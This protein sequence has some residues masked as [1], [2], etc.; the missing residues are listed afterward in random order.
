MVFSSGV[1]YGKFLK[2][3]FQVATPST[4]MCE[5]VRIFTQKKDQVSKDWLHKVCFNRSEANTCQ[6]L[7]R[8]VQLE[9]SSID[10]Q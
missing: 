4:G 9:C 8:Q 7:M 1:Y 5:N 10:Y 3:C 6:L 2:A